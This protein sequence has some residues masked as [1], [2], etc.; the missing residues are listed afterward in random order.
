MD[1]VAADQTVYAMYIK[2]K[3]SVSYISISVLL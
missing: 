3:K 2:Q 1:N